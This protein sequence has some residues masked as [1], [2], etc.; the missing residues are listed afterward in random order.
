MATMTELAPCGC[1]ASP[2]HGYIPCAECR[3]EVDADL[4]EVYGDERTEY[5][6]EW[7]LRQQAVSRRI[8][9][10]QGSDHAF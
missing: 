4:M 10:M 9:A 3:A 1:I 2:D 7:I 5:D 8:A 6:A